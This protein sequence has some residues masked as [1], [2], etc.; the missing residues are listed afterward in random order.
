M[1]SGAE[2]ALSDAKSAGR[3]C[4]MVRGTDSLTKEKGR[5]T[6]ENY[7]KAIEAGIVQINPNCK[8]PSDAF[9]VNLRFLFKE[10]FVQCKT[11]PSE[12]RHLKASLFLPSLS[13]IY[14]C[15][16]QKPPKL[17]YL[18]KFCYGVQD[19]PVVLYFGQ[20]S[21]CAAVYFAIAKHVLRPPPE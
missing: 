2:E 5:T 11:V 16:C 10:M 1:K 15:N 20:C 21:E 6:T 19:H 18:S 4:C 13:G 14:Y 17:V 9:P 12:W 3:N 7:S 8:K